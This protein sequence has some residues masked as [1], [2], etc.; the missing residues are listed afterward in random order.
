MGPE[1]RCHATPA[2]LGGRRWTEGMWRLNGRWPAGALL[3]H[4]PRPP[5]RPIRPAASAPSPSLATALLH[6]SQAPPPLQR[7][8]SPARP[9][10]G[11]K[12]ATMV[13]VP[14]TA[15]CKHITL[16]VAGEPQGYQ[17]ENA[18]LSGSARIPQS[19]PP[20]SHLGFHPT[21]HLPI[22]MWVG[23]PLFGYFPAPLAPISPNA[24]S[25]TAALN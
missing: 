21:S 6:G 16:R 1:W 17:R 9:N 22:Q 14:A 20:L 19:P 2:S 4:P 5:I 23:D 11:L 15:L 13:V 8:L 18:S 3:R 12:R 7:R 25:L 10:P 24:L